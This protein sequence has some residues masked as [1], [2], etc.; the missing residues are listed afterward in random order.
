MYADMELEEMV[1]DEISVPE[2]EDLLLPDEFCLSLDE[3]DCFFED[4][5]LD[6][7][8]EDEY[9]VA[10][11]SLSC[12]E[13]ELFVDDFCRLVHFSPSQTN[14]RFPSSTLTTESA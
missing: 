2:E 6:S 9:S 13:D 10:D 8:E 3:E 12:S 4:E 11:E 7:Y 5:D 14:L 1:L